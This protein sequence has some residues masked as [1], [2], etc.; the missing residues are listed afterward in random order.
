[1]VI[2]LNGEQ[3]KVFDGATVGETLSL[4][5]YVNSIQ[6]VFIKNGF[7]VSA[8]TKL[9]D[10]DQVYIVP[11]DEEIS[12]DNLKQFIV[13]RH[14]P[15]VVKKVENTKVAILG[16]GGL[17]SN[18]AIQLART[19]IKHLRLIDFDIVDP[20]NINR[21]NYFLDQIGSKKTKATLEN[22]KRV[23]PYIDIEIHDVYLEPA[24]YDEYLKDMD[25]V[26]EA[27]DNPICKADLT[28][29]FMQNETKQYLVTASGM[30]GYYSSNSIVTAKLRNNI[31]I[32]GDRTSA[33][34][35]FDGLM[36]PRVSIVAGHQSN[37]VLRIIMNEM[38]V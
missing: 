21:Q 31:Y 1:M 9:I 10:G 27:F 5:A 3:V 36:S 32:C 35:E 6:K 7:V 25:I 24:N 17:G 38:E 23:N 30:A 2:R 13:S 11:K 8:D 33:A 29:Y 34:K 22:L 15:E 12:E 28:R 18:I 16:L 14:S 37:C 26:V 20:T 4:T 19:G